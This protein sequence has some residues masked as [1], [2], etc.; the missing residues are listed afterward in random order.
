MCVEYDKKSKSLQ[1]R[2][3]TTHIYDRYYREFDF[4]GDLVGYPKHGNYRPSLS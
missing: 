3:D 1:T 2:Y 4:E